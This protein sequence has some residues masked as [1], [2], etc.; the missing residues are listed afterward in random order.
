MVI[1]KYNNAFEEHRQTTYPQAIHGLCIF[2]LV[3]KPIADSGSKFQDKDNALVKDQIA[4]FK[5]WIF[6]WMKIVGV[7]NK[8]EFRISY[9]KLM[10]WLTSFRT[11]DNNHL[12]SSGQAL[13][14]NSFQLEKLLLSIMNHK[15]RWFFPAR[16]HLL[17]LQQRTTS[18][19]EGVFSTTKRLSGKKV[20]PNMSLINSV[21]T[22]D[23]QAQN[24]MNEYKR[25][26]QIDIGSTPLWTTSES[27]RQ[28]TTMAESLKQVVTSQSSKYYMRLGE[29]NLC[30]EVLRKDQKSTFCHECEN[31]LVEYCAN[32]FQQSPIPRWRRTRKIVF[33]SVSQHLYAVRCDCLHND[34]YP[35]RHF[36][37][38]TEVLAGHFIPRYHK[39]YISFYGEP[40][41]EELTEHFKKRL[42]DR[43]FLVSDQ[44]K[45]A[46]F[47]RVRKTMELIPSNTWNVGKHH[48]I[49]SAAR[50]M[51][52]HQLINLQEE[53]TPNK[54]GPSYL[55]S[56]RS[57]PGN[58]NFQ[59]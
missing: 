58:W 24:R 50:G 7:E 38:I 34:G 40:G 28:L 13:A 39:K 31:N 17:H 1:V 25:Q 36:A 26:W 20:T 12:G 48:Q 32:C 19:L 27:S 6:T 23:L 57:K 8:E 45:T 33:E 16:Q 44:E 42:T 30:V 51:I 59:R 53:K 43:R 52:P 54:I 21:K 10:F 18:A 11:K 14:H 49:Q 56:G 35:C 4:T 47:A 2:H 46:I 22:Q 15:K 9:E 3:T 55:E 29:G 41:H 5:H 37:A